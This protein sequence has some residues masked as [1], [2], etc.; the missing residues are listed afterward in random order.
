VSKPSDCHAGSLRG[1]VAAGKAERAGRANAHLKEELSAARSALEHVTSEL[2]SLRAARRPRKI[3]KAA[4]T[5]RGKDDFVRVMFG[6]LHGCR[7]SMPAVSALLADLRVLNPDEIILGGDMMECGG[8]LAAHHVMG[9]VHEVEESYEEDIEATNAFFDRL[10]ETVPNSKLEYLEGNH[11]SRVEKWVTTQK[12]RSNKDAEYL[13]RAHCAETVLHLQARGIP[14]HRRSLTHDNLRVPGW[15]KRGNLFVT[16]EL[17]SGKNA[18]SRAVVDAGGNVAFFHTHR[19]SEGIMSSPAH[20]PVMA[21]N[22]GC[23]CRRQPLWK[24][25]HPSGWTHGYLVQFVTRSGNFLMQ[26]ILI[27]EGVSM[28]TPFLNRNK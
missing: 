14:Y 12:L 27:D 1:A 13:R 22:P 7:M 20:G 8:F 26:N 2:E 23:L 24:H 5:R 9:Y 10:Q 25:S 11:E 4:Q 18:G 6:D 17:S 21:W 19:R 15:I 16:H 28:L 3:P